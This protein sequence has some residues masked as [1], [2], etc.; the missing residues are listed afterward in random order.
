MNLTSYA[1][2]TLGQVISE[3]QVEIISVK[4]ARACNWPILTTHM[5]LQ[6]FFNIYNLPLEKY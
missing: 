6:M 3:N 2:S 1:L 5:E 4:I